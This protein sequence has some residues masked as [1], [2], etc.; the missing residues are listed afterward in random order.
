MNVKE[1]VRYWKTEKENALKRYTSNEEET[2]V[3]ILIKRMKLSAEQNEIMS[4]VLDVVLTDTY[5]SL[6]LGLDGSGSIGGIQQ[7]FKISDES[8]TVVSGR[9]DIEAEAWEQFHGD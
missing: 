2:E 4:S 3:S 7:A 9:G 8:G 5:Y 1:F 6:L